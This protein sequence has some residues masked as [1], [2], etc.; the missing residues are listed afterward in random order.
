ME[1]FS[2]S[3]DQRVV[4][5]SNQGS[6]RIVAKSLNKCFP[7]FCCNHFNAVLAALLKHLKL[8]VYIIK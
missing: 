8:F 1:M 5:S 4:S 6:E 2:D 3:R 7:V